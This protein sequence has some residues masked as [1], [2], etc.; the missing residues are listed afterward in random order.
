M[1]KDGHKRRMKCLT[2]RFLSASEYDK[3]VANKQAWNNFWVALG[4]GMACKSSR[5]ILLYYNIFWE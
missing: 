5:P 1:P 2:W 4:E 3:K